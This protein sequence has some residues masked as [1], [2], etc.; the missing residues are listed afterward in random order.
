MEPEAE[1]GELELNM[2]SNFRTSLESLDKAMRVSL[3]NAI[4]YISVS[5]KEKCGDVLLPLKGSLGD[6]WR[7]RNGEYSIIYGQNSS[8]L[9]VDFIYVGKKLAVT[10]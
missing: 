10:V 9:R 7:Y 3:V 2:T 8:L 5:P 4:K 6:F 1:V